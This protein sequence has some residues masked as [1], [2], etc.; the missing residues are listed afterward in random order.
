[1]SIVVVF[2]LH[3]EFVSQAT[4]AGSALKP[5]GTLIAKG[6][7]RR[8]TTEWRL[9]IRVTRL[10]PDSQLCEGRLKYGPENLQ[11]VLPKA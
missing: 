8:V 11:H 4:T 1:M 10:D 2:T 9:D 6:E 7:S 3:D 5:T